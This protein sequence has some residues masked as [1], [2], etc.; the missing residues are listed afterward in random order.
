MSDFTGSS[1]VDGE[2]TWMESL[3]PPDTGRMHSR[4]VLKQPSVIYHEEVLN[5][6]R[7]AELR[8][9]SLSFELW[10]RAGTSHADE[11]DRDATATLAPV[12]GPDYLADNR[13][14]GC[15]FIVI[16]RQ[17]FA[18]DLMRERLAVASS[19]YVFNAG[20]DYRG[21]RGWMEQVHPAHRTPTIDRLLFE[22]G[23]DAAKFLA[24]QDPLIAHWFSAVSCVTIE[25]GLSNAAYNPED[26]AMLRELGYVQV[27]QKPCLPQRRLPE[28][29][30]HKQ[31]FLSV[32]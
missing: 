2:P 23:H 26:D 12:Y 4:I 13:F 7:V 20:D 29:I 21:F 27:P 10:L 17:T 5:P 19:V 28:R 15:H 30:Y 16:L 32:Y 8:Q 3:P 25:T 31:L 9:H 6:G 24:L 22:L 14:A 18:R 1:S 11:F